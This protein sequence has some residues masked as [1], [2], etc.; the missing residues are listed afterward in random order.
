MSQNRIRIKL[1]PFVLNIYNQTK[2]HGIVW[3]PFIKIQ[4]C[5]ATKFATYPWIIVLFEIFEILYNS[6]L[7]LFLVY[8]EPRISTNYNSQ[9]HFHCLITFSCLDINLFLFSNNKGSKYRFYWT[10]LFVTV[11]YFT[12]FYLMR[13]CATNIMLFMKVSKYYFL[14]VLNFIPQCY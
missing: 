14:F 2:M 11:T 1:Y 10:Q 4:K 9:G 12:Y 5:F 13:L 3:I 6:S 8:V 7:L